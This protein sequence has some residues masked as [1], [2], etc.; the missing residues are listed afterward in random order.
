MEPGIAGESGTDLGVAGFAVCHHGSWSRDGTGESENGC[1]SLLTARAPRLREPSRTKRSAAHSTRAGER[2]PATA[3]RSRRE[4]AAKGTS[5]TIRNHSTHRS[6]SHCC[7]TWVS[8][9]LVRVGANVSL[10][11]EHA[12]YRRLQNGIVL[13]WPKGNLA[14]GEQPL[15][16][17]LVRAQIGKTWMWIAASLKP[18]E[19]SV[20]P[21]RVPRRA[22]DPGLS[23]TLSRARVQ[24]YRNR[25]DK[26]SR[27]RPRNPDKKSLGDPQVPQAKSG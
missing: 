4:C 1:R 16:W 5:E 12:D 27:D 9:F 25:T 11:S 23:I 17:R 3:K 6:G 21:G 24:R 20:P 14:S 7:G 10:L 13:C 15:R 22:A 18:C 19:H 8:A 26:K 2:R